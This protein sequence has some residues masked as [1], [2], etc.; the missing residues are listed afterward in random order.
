MVWFYICFCG[1]D[2][3]VDEVDTPARRRRAIIRPGG[4]EVGDPVRLSLDL[5]SESQ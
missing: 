3:A 2:L 1:R 4:G 5:V